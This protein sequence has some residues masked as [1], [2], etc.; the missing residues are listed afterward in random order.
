MPIPLG[1]LAQFRPSVAAGA[2]DLLETQVLTSNQAS[3]TFSGLAAYAA[4]YRHLQI[5]LL[6]RDAGTGGF[7]SIGIRFNG[8]SS[9][10]YARHELTGNGS[11]VSSAAN[12]SETQG[13]LGRFTHAGSAANSYAPMVIDLLDAYASKNKTVRV[14]GGQTQDS[15][16]LISTLWAST[17]SL[18]SL[19]I[20]SRLG[21]DIVAGS[22]FSLYGVKG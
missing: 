11:S 10:I 1:I 6:G 5:R 16:Y 2:F 14:L 7:S 3:V 21:V 20:Q 19:S 9:N 13:F 22:R 17:A 4:N 12:S 18:T 15:V 8:D